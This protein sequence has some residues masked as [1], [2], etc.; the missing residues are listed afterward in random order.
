MKRREFLQFSALGLVG[1]STSG[2]LAFADP[3]KRKKAS[4]PYSI[5][6]LGDTHFDT[7]PDTVYHSGYSD[8]NPTREANHRKEFGRNA[9]MWADR[10]PRLVKRAACLVDDDTKMVF[11]MGDLIQG[12]TGS[13]EMH[14]KMLSDAFSVLK[15][16]MG[17]LPLVT[18][19]GNHDIRSFDDS[20]SYPAYRECMTEKMSEELSQ[21]VE[22]TTFGFMVGPDA[23]IFVDFNKPDDEEIEKLLAKTEGARYT[24]VVEH[25]PLFPYESATSA[26]WILHGREKSPEARNHMRELFAR[27]NAIVLCGHTHRTEFLDWQG[28]AGRI[29]QMTM[30]SVWK[31]DGLA[32]YKV[33]AEGAAEYGSLAQKAAQKA[34]SEL[35]PEFVQMFNEVRPGI[36][37][38]STSN[39]AGSYKLTV[40]DEGVTVTLYGGDSTRPSAKFDLR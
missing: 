29:T 19:V 39:A 33:A 30:N 10:L 21:A 32:E 6:I 2:M 23:Y 40:S 38:Y 13:P 31:S 37:A 17:P 15:E 25:G 8:P 3:C 27:R 22:K 12:D 9:E 24:F 4:K 16:A 14:K 20:V 26:N 11:Q 34:G 5:V 18:V 36:K 35:K 7:D 28:E 1:M